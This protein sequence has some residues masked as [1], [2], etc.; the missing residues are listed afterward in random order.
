MA[1]LPRHGVPKVPKRCSCRLKGVLDEIVRTFC[2]AVRR[3]SI[4]LVSILWKIVRK[5]ELSPN[6]IAL[7]REK[8]TGV[9][10]K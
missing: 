9:S 10:V 6:V 5:M 2:E 7:L 3:D 4:V 8:D 1:K